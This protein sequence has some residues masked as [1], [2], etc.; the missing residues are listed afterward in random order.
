MLNAKYSSL[1][2]FVVKK[3]FELCNSSVFLTELS[4]ACWES[5]G[6]HLVFSLDLSLSVRYVLPH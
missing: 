5:L 4:F 1:L 6:F 3:G 2:P